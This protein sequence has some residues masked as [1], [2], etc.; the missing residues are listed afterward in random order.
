MKRPIIRL[1]SNFFI[2]KHQLITKRT[3]PNDQKSDA[4]QV[5]IASTSKWRDF[6]KISPLAHLPCEMSRKLTRENFF[7][8]KW[9]RCVSRLRHLKPPKLSEVA[10]CCSVLQCIAVCCSCS[11]CCSVL[12]CIKPPKLSEVAVYCSVLQCVA[13]CCS[14]L[15]FQNSQKLDCVAVCCSVL[16]CVAV[17]CSVLPCFESLRS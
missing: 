16:Q 11:V 5:F 4:W 1:L 7:I 13:V 6:S 17:C 8:L 12:Q 14:V 15:N 10:V 2:S 9:R 3:I